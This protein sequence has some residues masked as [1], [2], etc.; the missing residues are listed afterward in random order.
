MDLTKERLQGIIENIKKN[1]A[2][3]EGSEDA[4]AEALSQLGSDGKDTLQSLSI[5]TSE[6]I[7]RKKALRT[8]KADAED[9]GIELE[10]LKEK[11]KT[12]D[13]SKELEELRGFKTNTVKKQFDGF[14]KKLEA[15]K[16]H[17]NFGLAKGLFKLPE[18][19]E[20]GTYDLSKVADEDLAHNVAEMDK[21]EGLSYF[22]EIK[23]EVKDVDGEKNTSTAKSLQERISKATT[24]EEIDTI[25]AEMAS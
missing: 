11:L 14:G 9:T 24:K 8:M 1:S 4:F 19:K 3:V 17:A 22:G 21:L 10:E 2:P 16:G 25:Q 20:D 23:I 7:T 12:G 13:N 5:A 15:V 6:A 18:P